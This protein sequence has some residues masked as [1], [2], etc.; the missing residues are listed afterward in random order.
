[1]NSAAKANTSSAV[2]LSDTP[3]PPALVTE[4]KPAARTWTAAQSPDQLVTQGGW[5]CTAGKF[6]LSFGFKG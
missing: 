3:I 4:G 1:M 5:E 6:I 2:Q